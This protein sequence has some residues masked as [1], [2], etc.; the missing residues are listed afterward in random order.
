MAPRASDRSRYWIGLA[1]AAVLALMVPASAQQAAQ[2]SRAALTADDYARAE[3]FMGYNTTPL[4]FGMTVRPNWLV[5]PTK[6]A[7]GRK[8]RGRSLLVSQ[9]RCRAA[10]SSCW[11]IRRAPS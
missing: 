5:D 9:L 11:S 6:P 4:V 8:G 2:S 3:R 7:V 1:T 10:R